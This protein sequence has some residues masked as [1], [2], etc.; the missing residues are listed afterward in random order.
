MTSDSGE[1][2]LERTLRGIQ[3]A[4]EPGSRLAIQ[5]GHVAAD[6]PEIERSL[7]DMT[8]GERLWVLNR[9]WRGL[10]V[11]RSDVRNART[12]AGLPGSVAPPPGTEEDVREEVEELLERLR[13]PR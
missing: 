12:F 7:A 8:P 13:E 5:A 10:I 3:A 1:G 6:L 2:I 9:A 4:A 11:G